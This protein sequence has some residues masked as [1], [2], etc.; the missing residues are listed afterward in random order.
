MSRVKEF[1]SDVLFTLLDTLFCG[2]PDRPRD[3]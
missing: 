2:W 3:L 1:L